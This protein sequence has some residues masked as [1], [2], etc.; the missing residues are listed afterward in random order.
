MSQT[1]QRCRFGTLGRSVSKA[2]A[3]C[4]SGEQ[5][6]RRNAR[7]NDVTGIT[8]K[9]HLVEG[10]GRCRQRASGQHQRRQSQN[11]TL[12]TMCRVSA[13]LHSSWTVIQESERSGEAPS[14]K[15]EERASSHHAR[16]AKSEGRRRSGYVALADGARG[17]AWR[18]D[19][20][21]GGAGR[22]RVIPRNT[23][24]AFAGG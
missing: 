10:V 20:D 12:P 13:W 17:F 22:P 16:R 18:G 24:R 23:C 21:I 4:R 6:R 11:Q 8:C 3:I 15:P 14:L 19:G 5:F 7:G 2:N 1:G 9:R